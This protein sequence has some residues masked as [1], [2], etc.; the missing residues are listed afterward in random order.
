MKS[1]I[2]K[3]SLW[4]FVLAFFIFSCSS[5]K[6]TVQAPPPP[7]K[8]P[9]AVEVKPA[10]PIKPEPPKELNFALLLPLDLKKQFVVDTAAESE[11]SIDMGALNQLHFLE[12]A[13]LA[14]DSLKAKG[15]KVNLKTF[16]TAIDSSSLTNLLYQKDVMN[17]NCIF[18]A[19]NSAFYPA[20]AVIAQKHNNKIVFTQPSPASSIKQNKNVY[21]S[22]P[23]TTTQCVMAADYII[24]NFTGA[25][26]VV[27]SR[28]VKREKDLSDIFKSKFINEQATYLT[29][30]KEKEELFLTS[31]SKTTQNVLVITSSDEAFISPFLSK[32]NSL[33]M[34]NI[35]I[36]G[37]PTWENFESVD[38]S[39]L[40]NLSVIYFSSVYFDVTN[41]SVN[42]FRKN[43]LSRYNTEP[44]NSAFQG[45]ELVNYF[46]KQM[47][48]DKKSPEISVSL[49]PFQFSNDVP[50]NGFENKMIHILQVKDYAVSKK[51]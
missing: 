28:E 3:N 50:E 2:D 40:Q 7:V 48:G 25:H 46:T 8:P 38:F 41:A 11:S 5:S 20:A 29:H 26:I 15:I 35:T 37:L 47:I 24:K 51:N 23:T 10:E 43:F 6:K 34:A 14:A 17:S 42:A 32:I 9:V 36:V 33:N 39:A 49:I 30:S 27:V 22:V 45:F 19:F 21:L 31:L 4:F 16:D 1:N 13:M 12:G 18:A 44:L